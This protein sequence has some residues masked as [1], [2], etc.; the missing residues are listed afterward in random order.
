MRLFVNVVRKLLITIA[1]LA[2]PICA[3]GC[4]K[5]VRLPPQAVYTEIEPSGSAAKPPG[6][7]IP[8]LRHEPL[9]EYR[10]V[11]LVEGTGS[12][13]DSEADVLPVVKRKA[14]ESGA[15]AIVILTSKSQTTEGLVGYYLDAE[16]IVYGKNVNIPS[17]ESISH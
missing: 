2:A 1:F 4:V 15:D 10:K 7:D 3:G 11:G 17:G 13:Y 14:C 16:A 6:C 5:A 8:I 12:V 9:T